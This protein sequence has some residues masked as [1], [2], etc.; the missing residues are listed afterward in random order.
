MKEYVKIASMTKLH[1]VIEAKCFSEEE[2]KIAQEEIIRRTTKIDI[3][4]LTKKVLK[5]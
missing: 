1:E 4:E 5:K 2:K 3:Y